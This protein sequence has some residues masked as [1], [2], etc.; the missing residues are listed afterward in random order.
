MTKNDLADA[1]ERERVMTNQISHLSSVPAS[2]ADIQR[3]LGWSDRTT[4]ANEAMDGVRV[5]SLDPNAV[6]PSRYANRLE[7]NWESAAFHTLKADILATKGNLS[8]IKASHYT[9]LHLSFA[10][11]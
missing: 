6:A 1:E 11:L 4:S 2:A 5:V 3:P 7:F 9:Q 8:P 10:S